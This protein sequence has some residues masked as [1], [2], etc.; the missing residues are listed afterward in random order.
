[1]FKFIINALADVDENLRQ[2]YVPTDDG[3][4]RLN[5][6]GAVPRAKLDEFRENNIQLTK[7]LKKFEGIDPAKYQEALDKAAS[8]KTDDDLEALVTARTKA[9]TEQHQKIVGELNEKLNSTQSSLNNFRVSGEIKDVALQM[10]ANPKALPDILHRASS[11]YRLHEDRV[12]P[13]D[14]KGQVIYGTDG[15]NPRSP[16]EWVRELAVDAPHL[17]EQTKG[18]GASNQ[19]SHKSPENMTAMDKIAAGLE[20]RG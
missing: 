16:A 11:I 14:S 13:F 3:K 5:V 15:V 9:M 19:R 7:E 1:M 18:G 12:V 2:Y 4:F 17:F 8:A 20:E 10:G 6:E